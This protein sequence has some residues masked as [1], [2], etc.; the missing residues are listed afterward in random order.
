MGEPTFDPT[1]IPLQ[2]TDDFT[3]ESAVDYALQLDGKTVGPLS[4]LS[5]GSTHTVY[6]CD[7][8]TVDEKFDDWSPRLEHHPAFPERTTILWTQVVESHMVQVRIWERGV[9]ETLA[10]GTGACA[11]AVAAQVT[12]RAVPDASGEIAVVSRGG[13]LAVAWQPGQSIFMTGPA[14]VV[15]RGNYNL[16]F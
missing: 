16:D 2:R 8:K 7:Q 15:Y 4:S 13:V 10:C 1:A 6:F 12:G 14:E 5:T 9:G 3:G 11:A